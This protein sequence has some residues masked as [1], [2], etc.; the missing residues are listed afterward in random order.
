MVVFNHVHYV[1]EIGHR[2]GV[3]EQETAVSKMILFLEDH[4]F[5]LQVALRLTEKPLNIDGVSQGINITVKDGSWDFKLSEI[6]G[7]WRS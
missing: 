3:A 6:V 5:F 2:G 4:P 7:R 1:V